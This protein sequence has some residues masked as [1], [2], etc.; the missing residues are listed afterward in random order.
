MTKLVRL[1][2]TVT[3]KA[4]TAATETTVTAVIILVRMWHLHYIQQWVAVMK[5]SV[6]FTQQYLRFSQES[7]QSQHQS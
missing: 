6:S 4:L 3:A 7:H 2:L 5:S 1:T